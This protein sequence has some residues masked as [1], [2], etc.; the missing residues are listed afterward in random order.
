MAKKLLEVGTKDECRHCEMPVVWGPPD[1]DAPFVKAWYHPDRPVENDW[2]RSK[3][4]CEDQP[5]DSEQRWARKI[6]APKSYCVV[7]KGDDRICHASVVD[8]ELFMC[9][10]HSKKER[11]F[12]RRSEAYDEQKGLQQALRT[13]LDPLC[14][15]LNGFYELEARPEGDYRGY[16]GYLVV[17]PAKLVDL[18]SKIEEEF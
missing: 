16:T 8:E 2:A 18:I 5:D 4:F 15:H 1:P 17:N 14:D 7:P 12:L 3:V 11:E 10:T 6:A 9:G 13:F